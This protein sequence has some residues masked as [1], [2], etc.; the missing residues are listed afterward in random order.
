MFVFVCIIFI[1]LILTIKKRTNE[2]ILNKI[3]T[4]T[5]NGICT[6]FIFLSHST[7]YWSLSS[8]FFDQLYKHVQNIHNQWV[9]APFLAFSGYG[10]MISILNNKSYLQS[11]P[12]KR[13]LKTLI[14]FDVAVLLYWVIGISIGN[15]FSAPTVAL[16]FLGIT[17]LGN[18]NW[19]IFAI[20]IMYLLSYVVSSFTKDREKTA[21]LLFIGTALYI[22]LLKR[23]G[24]EERFYSTIMC[25][26]AGSAIALYKKDI[27]RL[28]SKYK[29][30][31]VFSLIVI[32]GVTYKL[33]IYTIIMNI[34]SIALILLIVWFLTFFTI[35][36]N[37]FYFFG[38]H[39]FSIFILQ[40]I[41]GILIT[42]F[43]NGFGIN[44]Y[45]LICLDFASTI[46]MALVY[47]K[48]LELL[49]MTLVHITEAA[50]R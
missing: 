23:F 11:F 26:P 1:L 43:F 13:I 9:V 12:Y 45:I 20:I 40:R 29:Y 47:D 5:I 14:N 35:D 44:K 7:Q 2:E 27:L 37:I 28:F 41:P 15:N 21:L 49:D 38:K 6:V 33:R 22:F 19:Y 10:V 46:G 25:Y 32:I 16:A 24:F 39:A 3:D 50:R 36:S 31:T 8:Q 17:S 30:A 34:S 4:V 42:V 48:F 18:S